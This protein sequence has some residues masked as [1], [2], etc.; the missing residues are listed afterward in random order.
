MKNYHL[1]CNG[2]LQGIF[3]HKKNEENCQKFINY[4][5]KICMNVNIFGKQSGVGIKWNLTL[6][7]AFLPKNL[8][9]LIVPPIRI[10]RLFLSP[11]MEAEFI[12]RTDFPNV[13]HNFVQNIGSIWRPPDPKIQEDRQPS[14]LWEQFTP[15]EYNQS[16]TQVEGDQTN[17][18]TF[19]N[20]AGSLYHTYTPKTRTCQ[21]PPTPAQ[22]QPRRLVA[23]T[24]Q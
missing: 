3:C 17:T 4:F 6:H 24:N 5:Q 9:A 22:L 23:H 19:P 21:S 11:D 16:S 10:H 15:V 1:L 14:P 2:G 13:V 12:A 8:G 20:D 18:N 7:P